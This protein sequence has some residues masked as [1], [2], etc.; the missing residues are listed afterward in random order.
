MNN[1]IGYV[2]HRLCFSAGLVLLVMTCDAGNMQ[3]NSRLVNS[4]SFQ[5]REEA[6]SYGACARCISASWNIFVSGHHTVPRPQHCISA[7]VVLCL[8]ELLVQIT[9]LHKLSWD[10]CASSTC[11]SGKWFE[12]LWPKCVTSKAG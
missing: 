10:W 3:V 11:C 4:I 6:V 7:S 9:L 2:E 5:R 8:S 12:T 1:S